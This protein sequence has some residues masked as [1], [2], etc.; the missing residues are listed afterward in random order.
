MGGPGSGMWYRWDTRT[1]L[2]QVHQLDVR[3][4]H[5]HGYLDHARALLRAHRQTYARFWQWV[6]SAV[7][8]AML[9][10]K[11]H[12]VFGWT[13]H[14]EGNVNPR[15]L[16]NYPMQGNASEM[17][18]LACSLATERGIEVCAPV[19]DAVLIHAPREEL[20]H[21]IALTQQCM[22]QA[23]EAVL[24]GYRLR[25]EAKCFM[26]PEH[27]QDVRGTE[28]WQTVQGLLMPG[29]HQTVELASALAS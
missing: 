27:Y 6:E 16:S 20:P 15:T 9:T 2:D 3:W 13:L 22:Q 17:L 23:S 28:M 29:S 12:T 25:T 11:L 1:T 19:H 14:V 4:L 5:R 7:D 8:Y 18:R 10:R 24:A 21:A 26:Y